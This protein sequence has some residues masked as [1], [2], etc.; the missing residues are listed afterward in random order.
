ME[1]KYFKLILLIKKF[2]ILIIIF[3]FLIFLFNCFF[4]YYSMRFDYF[5]FHKNFFSI[6][7]SFWFDYDMFIFFFIV[8]FVTIYVCFF[9]EIYIEFYNLKKYFFY[10]LVF[11]SS[12]IMLIYRNSPIIFILSWD[13]LGI[14][15]VFLI[16]FYP[17]EVSFFNSFFTIVFN[18]FGDF[19][20]LMFLLT[21]LSERYIYRN[22]IIRKKV[23]LFLIFCIITKRAQFPLSTWLPLAISAPTPISTM[24][25]SSTL[26]TAGVFI[27]IKFIDLFF[28]SD[29]LFIFTFIRGLTFIVGGFLAC[30]EI[31]FKKIIAFSTIRQIRIIIFFISFNFKFFAMLHIVFHA[32]FKRFL[33]SCA[34][35]RFF[36]YFINQNK[37]FVRIKNFNLYYKLF[38]FSSVYIIRGFLYSIR[39]YRKDYLL[40]WVFRNYNIIRFLFFLYLGR[41]LTMI[42]CKVLIYS[43]NNLKFFSKY[44][45]FK[46]DNR[47]YKIYFFFSFF[48]LIVFI[49]FF[50]RYYPYFFSSDLLFLNSLFILFMLINLPIRIFFLKII[51]HRFYFNFLLEF[52]VYSFNYLSYLIIDQHYFLKIRYLNLLSKLNI[53]KF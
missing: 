15:S 53:Y 22:I 5:F 28:Y 14:S 18:R 43:C 32:Y 45:F 35:M 37:R 29:K 44:F 41:M 47:I 48:F 20:L 34:G 52:F 19:F 36:Y 17:N 16:L 26:V 2:F 7:F 51:Y 9:S 24:V 30:N 38:I 40:E 46:Y 39:F 13:I 49:Y 50:L 11:F 12:I 33:F 6:D 3:F 27:L 21:L 23:Y 10:L 31:D 42:Y 25:H 1:S 8:L 4:F